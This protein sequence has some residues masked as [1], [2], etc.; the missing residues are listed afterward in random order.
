MENMC[1][2]W[3]EALVVCLLGKKLGFKTMKMKLA[4]IWNH[5]GDFDLM[6][7]DNGFYMVRFDLAVDREKVVGGGPWMIFDHYLAVSTWSRQF[8]SPSAKVTKTLAWIRIPGSTRHSMMKG[9]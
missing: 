7:V 4:N 5:S 9:F 3:K 2:P 6:D 1:E 8:I